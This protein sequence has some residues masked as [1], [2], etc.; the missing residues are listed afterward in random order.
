M[1][2]INGNFE[3]NI[4]RITIMKIKPILILALITFFSSTFISTAQTK[5]PKREIRAVWVATV[6]NIDWPSRFGLPVEEQKRL[7][8]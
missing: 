3:N 5:F 2:K 1:P 7:V 4:F 6:Y 8:S